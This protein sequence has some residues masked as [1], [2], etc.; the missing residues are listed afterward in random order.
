MSKK[1]ETYEATSPIKRNGKTYG[2]G[3]TLKLSEEEAE[4][5]HVKP[6]EKAEV[7][8]PDDDFDPSKP[9]HDNDA[10]DSIDYIETADEEDLDGF[11]DPEKESRVTVR[12]AWDTR[13]DTEFAEE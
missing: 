3:D 8:D 1:K 7:S 6:A 5:L 13:F 10:A 11:F 2:I 12:R 9:S 4:G